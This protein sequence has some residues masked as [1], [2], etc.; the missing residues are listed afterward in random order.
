MTT[1]IQKNKIYG[2]ITYFHYLSEHRFD[3]SNDVIIKSCELLPAIK[4]KSKRKIK[5]FLD[6]LSNLHETT[7]SF[8]GCLKQI[9][10]FLGVLDLNLF[11]VKL[12]KGN[13]PI[14]K[15]VNLECQIS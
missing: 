3:S 15:Y 6:K 9:L 11:T 4:K 10:Y 5:I 2:L 1:F 12:S 14:I 8:K 7:I 13:L